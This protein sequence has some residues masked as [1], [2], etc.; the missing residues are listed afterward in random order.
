MAGQRW[1]LATQLRR[2]I[3]QAAR[4]GLAPHALARRAGI[5]QAQLTR[6]LQSKRVVTI[7]TADK[8]ARALGCEIVL[9]KTRKAP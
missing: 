6:L 9:S 1:T 5:S 2:A 3:R 4:E 7:T 8:I